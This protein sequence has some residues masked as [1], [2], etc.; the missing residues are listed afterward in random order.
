MEQPL[1]T[2]LSPVYN[3]DKYISRFIDSILNLDYKNIE[4]ILVNDGSVDETDRIINSYKSKLENELYSFK[5]IK[6]DNMGAAGAINTGLKHVTGKYLTWPDSDD[7]LTPNSI[8]MKV[9]FLEKNKEYGYVRTEALAFNEDDLTKPIY[10][11]KRKDNKN[12]KTDLFYEFLLD[13]NIYYCDGCYMVRMSCFKKH[14]PKMSIYVTKWGQNWQLFLPISYYEK[15]GYIKDIGYYYLERKSSH[16]H[17]QKNYSDFLKKYNGY[18]DIII[19]VLD[20]MNIKEKE[21]LKKLVNTKYSHMRLELAV[22]YKKENNF[23]KEYNNLKKL[24]AITFKDK[25]YN[26]FYNKLLIQNIFSIFN[27][28]ISIPR[29]IKNKIIKVVCKDDR[30]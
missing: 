2:I 19:N 12:N 23:K 18:E 1:V 6:Q 8:S 30:F 10:R 5:Y 24:N 17:N 22:T 20:D 9:D 4:F 25:L 27:D 11:I 15:C 14:N 28:L 13:K 29:R 21:K 26:N 16:S 7:V 3:G